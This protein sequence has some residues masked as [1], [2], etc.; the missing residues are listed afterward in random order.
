LLPRFD[1]ICFMRNG[2]IVEQGSFNELLAKRGAFHKLWQ[3]HLA[4]AA[5]GE[6]LVH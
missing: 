6:D 3:H 5:V 2:E 1:H 4:Q